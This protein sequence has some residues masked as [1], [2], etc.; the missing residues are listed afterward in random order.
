[1]PKWSKAAFQDKFNI[2]KGK[3]EGKPDVDDDDK[4]AEIDN[5]LAKLQSKLRY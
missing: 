5:N 2:M 1:M 3:C 4:Y